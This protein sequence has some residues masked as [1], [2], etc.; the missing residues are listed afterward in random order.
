MAENIAN[1]FEK[2]KRYN[3]WEGQTIQIGYE[4]KQ[5]LEKITEFLDTRLVKVLVGQ[6]RSGKSYLLRQIMNYLI[7][8]K[9]VDPKNLFFLNKEFIAF[10]EIQTASD[11]EELFSIYRTQ[12][13][14]K[15]KIYIFLD[16]VQNIEGWETFVN[17]YSQDFTQDYELFV[18]G[19]NSTLIIRR[20]SN[21]TIRQIY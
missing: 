20:I 13:Q 19:S 2:T 15:G 16:E 21:I 14:V 11:L 10:D 1:I 5:Y 9:N 7:K 8:N 17:S 12:L 3:A 4:R 18:S 6:R